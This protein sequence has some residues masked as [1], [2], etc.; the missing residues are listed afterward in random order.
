[1]PVMFDK[2]N[3]VKG[4]TL[5][6]FVVV[7]ALAAVIMASVA[8]L[9]NKGSDTSSFSSASD[10]I[11]IITAGLTEK[12]TLS[13]GLPVAD[14]WS[15]PSA[16][17]NYIPSDLRSKWSYLCVT[18]GKYAYI[19]SNQKCKDAAQ[20]TAILQ[21]LIDSGVC[22]AYTGAGWAAGHGSYTGGMELICQIKAL[23]G[24]KCQ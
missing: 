3:G 14:S 21:R 6:E 22:P 15:W 11:K 10:D 12:A 2:K 5:L 8:I 19:W 4:F 13:K 16:L 18:G 24:V 7:I 23:D 1:M 20:C 9:I 17:Q